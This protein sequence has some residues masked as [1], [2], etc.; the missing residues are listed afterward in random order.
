MSV[1][2]IP[3]VPAGIVTV[4]LNGPNGWY[5]V[6]VGRANWTKRFNLSADEA[7]VL[8]AELC[9]TVPGALAA[10]DAVARETSR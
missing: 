6:Q 4:T 8:V 10:A 3:G 9:R 1:T 2:E 5:L 7:A